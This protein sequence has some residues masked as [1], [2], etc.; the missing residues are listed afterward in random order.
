MQRDSDGNELTSAQIEYFK[1]SKIRDKDGN[2][3]VVMYGTKQ[4]G[5]TVFDPKYSD[6]R[7]SLFFKDDYDTA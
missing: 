1:D 4:Y 2:L 6:D 5:F 7:R 3:K